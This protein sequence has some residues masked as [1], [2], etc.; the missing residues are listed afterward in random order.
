MKKVLLGIGL[1][2]TFVLFNTAV[3]GQGITT[4]SIN[5][6]ITSDEGEILPGSIIIA[7][8]EPSGTKYATT[9]GTSGSFNLPS[10]KVGGP[11]IIKI[12]L[13]GYQEKKDSSIYLDLGEDLNLNVKLT[14]TSTNLNQVVISGKADNTFNSSRTGSNTN[15]SATQIQM[16]PSVS[17][18]L[19]DYMRL[20][21]QANNN[22]GGLSYA[23]A[24]NRYNNF[25]I[26]G[27]VN[28][29][30]FGLS[31]SGTN[32]GTAG[33]QP[34]SL[35][36]IQTI[37]VAISPYDVK[38]GGFTGA[39][40]NAVTKSGTNTVMGD[41]YY[42][43]NNQNLAGKTPTNDPKVVRT[44]LSN[45][46]SS[47]MGLSVGGP[48]LKDKLFFFFNGE[49]TN[50]LDPSSYNVGAG[51]NIPDSIAENIKNILLEKTG[52][53]Y[54]GGGYGPYTN[55]TTSQ[56]F[57]ARIDWNINTNN[58]LTIRNNYVQASED[59][60]SRSVNSLVFNDGGYTLKSKTNNTVVELDSRF[61]NKLAN[62]LRIGY[63]TVRDNRVLMGQPFPSVSITINAQE[64]V[65][66]GSEKSSEANSLDQNISTLSD[67][68][69]IYLN[70]NKITIGTE[71]ELYHFKN[72]FIQDNF[73]YYV[74]G[75]YD[76]FTHVIH[77][78][79]AQVHDWDC[80][81]Y[82]YYYSTLKDQPRWAAQFKAMQLGF[83]AQ[84][85][86]SMIKNVKITIGVRVDVPVFPDKPT[87]NKAFDTDTNFTK[88][89]VAT[90]QMPKSTPLLSPRIGFNWDVNG[91]HKTQIRGGTGIF[92]GRIPFVWL[93]NQFSNTGTEIARIVDLYKQVAFNPDPY[94][95]AI[96]LDSLHMPNATTEVDVVAKNFKFAQNFRTNLA[97]DQKLPYG[98]KVTLEGIYTKVLND[99]AYQDITLNPTI[100]L[101][102]TD[103]RPVYPYSNPRIESTLYTHVMYLTNTN[104][105]YSYTLT[106]RVEKEFTFGLGLTGAYTYGQ[107]YS[108]S[109]GTASV[110]LSNWQNNYQYNSPNTPEQGI[111]VYALKNRFVG[112]LTY[113]IKYIKHCIT[114]L[115]L[116]YNGQSGA[117]FSYCYYGDL[118][119]DGNQYNDLMF[120]PS[121][122]SDIN[123]AATSSLSAAEQ[124]KELNDFIENDK[125]L[126]T[127][128]GKY[129]E[130][131]GARAPF[132][133][134]LDFRIAQDYYINVAGKKNTL[135]VNFDILNF[136]N[137]LNSKWGR[138]YYISYSQDNLV[139]YVP[140]SGTYNFATPK[141]TPWQISDLASRWLG[142]IGV[143]YIFD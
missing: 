100:P 57:F 10:L 32:G 90:N 121:K 36:A 1:L 3:S 7:I 113:K 120:V 98:I 12:S 88:Y 49:M 71:D 130:R 128:R 64:H 54:D 28:N 75:S 133:N 9:S 43:F 139:T 97:V 23:G 135:E 134:H 86:I 101:S 129:A 77:S 143:K 29:D 136:T 53:T 37:N 105:G 123:L 19:T 35:D 40:I 17:R 2:M 62:E 48:I 55:K 116:F 31:S 74:Y 27:S 69:S 58:K 107:A 4:S 81:N 127:R 118:N 141:S 26:D 59:N 95:Q 41:A 85:E 18:S 108:I 114:T 8:H 115:G 73:G 67:N 99:I 83:Y 21:P 110:A 14:R 52:G 132:E 70:K 11:Y 124:W 46:S 142:Q 131:N 20:T 39:G 112:V 6:T 91:E 15:I 65:S 45:F 47:Q 82:T 16:L 38:Q 72:L 140:A 60:L 68:L 92:T 84:D 126:K 13:L 138:S 66:L 80:A 61:S 103:P 34:I 102:S 117:P 78:D 104:K 24:N 106:A 111:S 125:Y 42:F 93:S 25:S 137:L 89:G 5:G 96:T 87:E 44:K 51:S 109:D 122:A 119:N 33:T 76:A 56:K 30:V 50:R 22:S 94:N 79:S 63:T